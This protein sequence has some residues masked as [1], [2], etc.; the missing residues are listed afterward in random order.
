MKKILQKN[1]KKKAED[2][3]DVQIEWDTKPTVLEM[4]EEKKE[5]KA[6]KSS[7]SQIKEVNAEYTNTVIR[8]AQ[9][10]QSKER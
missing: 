3:S 1:L 6:I 7:V 8:D 2:W 5:S 9:K 10:A 4:P